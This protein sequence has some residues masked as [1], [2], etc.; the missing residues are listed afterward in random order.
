LFTTDAGK[1]IPSSNK[2]PL[3]QKGSLC[4]FGNSLTAGRPLKREDNR[5]FSV[6]PAEFA[7]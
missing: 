7:A 2:F 4:L 5:R 6:I 1:I 3:R